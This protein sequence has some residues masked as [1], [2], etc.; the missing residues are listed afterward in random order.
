MPPPLPTP[1][2]PVAPA[3]YAVVAFEVFMPTAL[4]R[5][6]LFAACVGELQRAALQMGSLDGSQRRLSAIAWFADLSLD[7]CPG[8][9][10]RLV[11]VFDECARCWSPWEAVPHAGMSQP[12]QTHRGRRRK[13]GVKTTGGT[14]DLGDSHG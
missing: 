3:D 2:M 8:G 11:A 10:E 1:E 7:S 6:H 4:P 13:I 12:A 5:R 9:R 14:R